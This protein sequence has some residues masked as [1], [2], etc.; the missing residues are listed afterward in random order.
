MDDNMEITNQH[1]LRLYDTG[2]MPW[3]NTYQE[4]MDTMEHMNHHADE[5]MMMNMHEGM[6]TFDHD[7][8]YAY[9]EH[10]DDHYDPYEGMG[11]GMGSE[12]DAY[13]DMYYRARVLKA[14]G[15]NPKH[16]LNAE[17]KQ[18]KLKAKLGKYAKKSRKLRA[19]KRQLK[20]KLDK[21]NKILIEDRR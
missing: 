18:R 2:C 1:D 10:Y 5:A 3:E 15:K 17:K 6:E 16:P 11:S 14:S 21:K 4:V 9:E 7:M 12:M 13:Y 8:E 20:E 19:Q